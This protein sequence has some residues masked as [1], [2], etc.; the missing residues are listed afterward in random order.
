M[1]IF[2]KNCDDMISGAALSQE[3][4]KPLRPLLQKVIAHKIFDLC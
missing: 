4:L 1:Y 2:L 3:L